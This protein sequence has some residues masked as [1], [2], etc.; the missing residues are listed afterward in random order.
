MA[1]RQT[2]EELEELREEDVLEQLARLGHALLG[3]LGRAGRWLSVFLRLQGRLALVDRTIRELEYDRQC[4]LQRLGEAAMELRARGSA[5][6]SALA[7]E[8]EEVERLEE[9][10]ALKKAE[11]ERLRAGL[12]ARAARESKR[13]F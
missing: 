11:R 10:I 4:A 5:D 12:S 3:A 1:R 8:M 2:S 7:R 6:L 13:S 9:R